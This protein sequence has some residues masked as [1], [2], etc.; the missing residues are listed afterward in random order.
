MKQAMVAVSKALIRGLL[1]VVPVYLA[2]LLLLKGMK[3]VAKLVRPFTALLPDW[4]PAEELLSLLLV[5]AICAVIG[6]TVGTRI[7]RGLGTGSNG[8]SSS[9]SL[10]MGS[11][12][13]SRTRWRGKQRE[14][15]EGRA[16]RDR[17]CPCPGVHHRGVRGRALHRLRPVD[18]DAVRGCRLRSRSA[19]GAS[20][21][22]AV[23]RCDQ[24]H[25]ALGIGR[26]E[27]GCGDG[28]PRVRRATLTQPRLS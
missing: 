14:H 3:S 17:R 27:P 26:E 24:G 5:L 6:A 13:A 15:L 10:A 1:I 8:P 23:H 28:A 18:P 2:I 12:A 19:A 7:G 25:L 22:R 11:S 16:G 9:E 4:V 21:G 20:G